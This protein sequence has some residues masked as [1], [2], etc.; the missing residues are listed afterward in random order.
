MDC[1]D[2]C[3]LD[4]RDEAVTAAA[5]FRPRPVKR[6][7][8][9]S[10][11]PQEIE[12]DQ[13]LQ[14]DRQDLRVPTS[15]LSQLLPWEVDAER[16]D[17]RYAL[18]CRLIEEWGVPHTRGLNWISASSRA[19]RL[20]QPFTNVLMILMA[21]ESEPLLDVRVKR[22]Y[23]DW[24]PRWADTTSCASPIASSATPPIPCATLARILERSN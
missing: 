23:I 21:R 2:R 18:G 14:L 6:K 20:P 16:R 24:S 7:R 15:F 12:V 4:T 10:G 3:R 5:Q 22:V 1:Q 19:A 11:A 13:I 17:E 8:S 9:F